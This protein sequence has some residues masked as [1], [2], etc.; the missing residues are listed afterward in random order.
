M[1]ITTV[2]N[3]LDNIIVSYGQKVTKNELTQTTFAKVVEQIKS[4]A[5]KTLTEQ[6]QQMTEKEK[7]QGA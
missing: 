5:W 1:E 2:E 7:Q 3:V 4:D 6:L